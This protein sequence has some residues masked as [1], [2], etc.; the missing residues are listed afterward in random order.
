MDS[1]TD[2]TLGSIQKTDNTFD[3]ALSQEGLFFAVQTP[4]GVRLTRDGSFV[5]NNDGKLT[6]KQGF[7]VLGSDGKPINI[8]P[9]DNI[10]H[11][12]KNGKFSVNTPGGFNFVERQSLYIAAP[13]NLDKLQ[14]EGSN[15]Y[16]F[17]EGDQLKPQIQTNSVQQGFVEKSNVNAIDM[18]VK[19]IETNRL[20]GMYQKVMDTQMNDLNQDAINKLAVTKA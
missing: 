9:E 8:N 5:V 20:V 3:F 14:K 2:Q 10:I 4:N 15:L 16:K 13:D 12:D 1:Y 6:T 17:D 11:V 7:D 19:M 18:M